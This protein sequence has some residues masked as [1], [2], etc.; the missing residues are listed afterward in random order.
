MHTTIHPQPTKIITN[1]SAPASLLYLPLSAGAALIRALRHPLAAPLRSVHP[2]QVRGSHKPPEREWAWKWA[3]S[4]AGNG[5]LGCSHPLEL[6]QQDEAQVCVCCPFT[7]VCRCA[8][9][10]RRSG[11][12]GVDF[13]LF[14]TTQGPAGD[15]A[16]AAAAVGSSFKF[17][18]APGHTSTTFHAAPNGQGASHPQ[19][20]SSSTPVAVPAGPQQQHQ[21]QQ[22][23][24]PPTLS[25]PF[26]SHSRGGGAAAN[27][28]AGMV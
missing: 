27:G 25:S 24:Q 19:A 20:P 14:D 5:V 2:A 4:R 22:L 8:I 3:A 21:Q 18:A 28:Y 11:K 13:S 7:G 16:A 26:A 12:I 23:E 17:D 9:P 6:W 15:A 10:Y 1:P